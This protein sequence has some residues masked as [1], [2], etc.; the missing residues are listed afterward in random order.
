M[1]LHTENHRLAAVRSY[2]KLGFTPL[3]AA[4]AASEQQWADVLRRAFLRAEGGG[5]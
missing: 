4:G 1:L 5:G 3:L 2:F